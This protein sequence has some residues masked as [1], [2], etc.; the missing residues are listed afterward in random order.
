MEGWWK[1]DYRAWAGDLFAGPGS[2]FL[3]DVHFEDLEFFCDSTV[4]SQRM[5]KL[6]V[7]LG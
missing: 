6:R 1:G 2:D 7:A 3:S 4:S 5:R